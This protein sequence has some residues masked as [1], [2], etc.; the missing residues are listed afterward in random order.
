MLAYNAAIAPA[1]ARGRTTPAP[2]A[3]GFAAPVNWMTVGEATVAFEL[4]RVGVVVV[5]TAGAAELEAAP[6]AGAA[7]V[8]GLA[9]LAG[10]PGLVG[11]AGAM[12]WRP[13]TL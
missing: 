10:A 7:L 11:A 4:G 5:P 2:T 6:P 3:L 13:V 9:G 8:T 1:I 12:D